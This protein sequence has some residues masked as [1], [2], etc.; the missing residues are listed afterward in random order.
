MNSLKKNSFVF[1]VRQIFLFGI[2]I[3]V[4]LYTT[5]KLSSSDFGFIVIFTSILSAFSILSDGGI[6]VGFIQG[7]SD[8]DIDLFG[9]MISFV[10]I[11]CG[12]MCSA[13]IVVNVFLKIDPLVKYH[14][15]YYL[16]GIVL[17]TSIQS[18][19]Y[20]KMQRDFKIS[21]IAI[22][23]VLSNVIY[24][25]TIVLLLEQDMGLEG[26]LIATFVKN[27]VLLISAMVLE[28][29]KLRFRIK[30]FG[31][32]FWYELRRGF[33][34]QVSFIVNYIRT[35]TNPII[36]NTLFDSGT[37]GLVDRAMMFA[38]IPSNII[39][40]VSQKVLFPYFSSEIRENKS[41]IM[42]IKE[43]VFAASIG[44]KLY[45]IPLMLL[46]EPFVNK[47]LGTQ[48]RGIIPM[49]YLLTIG[50]MIWGGVSGVS[51][52]CL[53]GMGKFKLISSLNI[54]TT[55]LS[56]ILSIILTKTF[57]I[58]GFVLVSP[59]LWILT[60]YSVFVLKRDLGKFMIVYEVMYPVIA[61]S[62]TFG[63]VSIIKKY[64]LIN[65]LLLEMI[66]FS[67]LSYMIYF[68]IICLTEKRYLPMILPR[69][70]SRIE[71]LCHGRI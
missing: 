18:V 48:W 9:T 29:V 62:I 39:V 52:A 4:N 33:V 67:F 71:N 57:G 51:S 68:L 66:F 45:Y 49:I 70:K 69:I 54:V 6:W 61:S 34:N 23:D 42:K 43:T 5:R 40:V 46:I 38:G 20:S 24:A 65:N 44:D 58:T 21:Q 64:V 8:I 22:C 15:I 28:R 26:F 14:S 30:N 47:Y 17:C 10:L 55:I 12:L 2:S 60:I 50:N 37:V 11:S 63:L 13:L 35:L 53:S 7:K 41:I 19:Y 27:V 1:L 16:V 3:A 36:I 32:V 59:I 31:K 56:W 25:I